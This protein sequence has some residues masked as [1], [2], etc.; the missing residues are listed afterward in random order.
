VVVNLLTVMILHEAVWYESAF[1]EV[2]LQ[3]SV[4]MSWL[5]VIYSTRLL[6]NKSAIRVMLYKPVW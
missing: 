3:D 1:Y 6:D 4:I 2:V 5:N